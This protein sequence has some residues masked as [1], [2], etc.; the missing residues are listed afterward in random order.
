M[1][2][3]IKC[4]RESFPATRFIGKRYGDEDRVNGG[5][6]SQWG[7]WF[8]NGWF[9]VIEKVGHMEEDSGSYIGLMSCKEGEPFQ[10]WVGMFTPSDTEVPDGF[11]Y[12]DFAASDLGTC[13]IYGNEENDNIYGMHDACCQKM[14]E[15]SFQIKDDFGNGVG[16]FWF[17][18]RYNCPRFTT[19]D[20]NG[21]IIL[22]YCFYI[23]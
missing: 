2:E 1:A 20:E 18:E 10:Y 9:D 21:K 3:I 16:E 23:K 17:Y 6:G 19:P 13:W 12:I 7:E 4:F 14:N 15:N 11:D 8:N 22:D 5:F